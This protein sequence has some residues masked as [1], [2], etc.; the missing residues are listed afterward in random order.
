MP[1]LRSDETLRVFD[2]G[3][4]TLDPALSRDSGSHSYI[5]NIFSGLVK[6][7]KDLKL[8]PDIA[9]YWDI[10]DG[11]TTYIFHLREGAK[12][13]D[14][15]EVTAE[16]FKYSWERACLPATKSLTAST[17]L[18]DIIGAG[19]VLSGKTRNLSGVEAVDKYTL[20]VKIA[21]P[22]AY[23][24][25][26]LS[27][28]VSFVVEKSNLKNGNE[29]WKKPVGTGPFKLNTW[30]KDEL[31]ILERNDFYYG[32]KPDLK[33]I[34]FKLW[35]GVPTQMYEKGEIDFTFVGASEYEKVTDKSNPLNSELVT[36][37]ELSVFYIGFNC[38]VPPFDDLNFRRA[39]CFSFDRERIIKAT[40][41]D[42]V[43]PASGILPPELPGHN[44]NLTGYSYDL[45]K[46]RDFLIKSKYYSAGNLPAVTITIPGM[47]NY[48][49]SYLEA[50]INSWRIN[51]GIQIQVRQLDDYYEWL[52]EEKDN[53][54]VFGWVAD[55]PDP[56]NFLEVLFHS[57]SQSNTGKYHNPE[58]DRFLDKAGIEQNQDQRFQMYQQIEE[59]ILDDAACIPLWYNL[60]YVLV[61]PYVKDFYLSPMGYPVLTE[62]QLQR[63]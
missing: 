35:S 9:A 57:N 60:N 62:I 13:H 29:W 50:I 56:Q 37:P 36:K 12:F 40:M 8:Q 38:A 26:K 45:N 23:F 46:A 27:Y 20:K 18:N 11:G 2:T 44:K 53:L 14:G 24:L 63:R 48:I 41:K 55:Y 59:G 61:K 58:I 43:L 31:I 54:F 32:E 5:I 16:D 52:E 21:A 22:V 10:K 6:F 33:Y 47:D 51:L 39:F 30:K 42:T 7:D 34:Q 15:T 25:D 49:P 17:Y 28:P 3:P 1:N 4:Q 19:E